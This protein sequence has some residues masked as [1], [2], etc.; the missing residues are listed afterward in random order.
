MLF[1]C[2]VIPRRRGDVHRALVNH[3]EAL[4]AFRKTGDA[5]GEAQ[6]LTN[7]GI[8]LNL[9]GEAKQARPLL[10][11]ASAAYRVLGSRLGRR[12]RSRDSAR[13]WPPAA[14]APPPSR[15]TAPRWKSPPS[16]SRPLGGP[17]C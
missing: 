14:S 9:R 15:A 10:H 4:D 11:K 7:I 6:A 16:C 13:R 3:R 2:G 5:L 12:S 1:D 17:R 8:A